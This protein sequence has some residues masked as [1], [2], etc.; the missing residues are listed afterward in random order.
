MVIPAAAACRRLRCGDGL[1]AL[2]AGAR[3]K[4]DAAS[5]SRAQCRG[6][7]ENISQFNIISAASGG[8]DRTNRMGDINALAAQT[9]SRALIEGKRLFPTVTNAGGLESVGWKRERGKCYLRLGARLT[10]A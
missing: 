9:V 3:S 5:I 2:T 7:H 1:F 10:S 4:V 8:S 6:N